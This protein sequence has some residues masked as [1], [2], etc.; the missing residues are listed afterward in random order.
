MMA[1]K[2]QGQTL[3]KAIIDLQSCKGTE[4]PYVML[5]RVKSLKGLLI[6]RP[7]EKKKIQCRQSEDVRTEMLRLEALSLETIINTSNNEI[8]KKNVN[9]LLHNL[10][11]NKR[12]AAD[13]DEPLQRPK[14][15]RLCTDTN[16]LDESLQNT[17]DKESQNQSTSKKANKK[18]QLEDEMSSTGIQH[19][20][21][22]IRLEDDSQST[23]Q[24]ETIN[25]RDLTM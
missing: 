22:K 4:A 7:F 25:L 21:K 3:T 14:K 20:L 12:K 24:H 16:N 19:R 2:A 5:S 23:R 15:V 6:L 17:T 9:K 13:D 1:H 8:E 10:H 11:E 18:R